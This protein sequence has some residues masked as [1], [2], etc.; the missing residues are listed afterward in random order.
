M[1][2]LRYATALLRLRGQCVALDQADSFEM[3]GQHATSQK[4][5]HASAYDDRVFSIRTKRLAHISLLFHYGRAALWRGLGRDFITVL[6]S[7]S[8][9]TILVVAFYSLPKKSAATNLPVV[10]FTPHKSVWT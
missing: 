10:G 4:S 8:S 7:G 3:I 9:K 6:S 2:A 5:S 1:A